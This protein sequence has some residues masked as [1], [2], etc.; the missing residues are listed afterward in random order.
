MIPPDDATGAA[1]ARAL[2]TEERRAWNAALDLWRVRMGDPALVDA[3]PDVPSFA[4]FGFPPRVHVDPDRAAQLGADD[5]LES[6]FA[7]EIGHHVLS[8][9]TRLGSLTLAAQMGRAVLAANVYGIAPDRMQR[10]AQWLSNVWSDLLINTRIVEMQR[11]RGERPTGMERLWVAVN[12]SDDPTPEW[13]VLLRATEIAWGRP[14]GTFCPIEPPIAPADEPVAG[15]DE[16]R[17]PTDLRADAELLVRTLRGFADDPVRGALRF[18][19][20]LAPYLM[21]RMRDGSGGAGGSGTG[22]VLCDGE[23]D[24][25]PATAA[26][27]ERVLADARLAE[28]PVHPA[29]EVPDAG[30]APADDADGTVSAAGGQK[31][32][33][34]ETLQLFPGAAEADA[35]SAWYQARARPHVAPLVE[36]APARLGDDIPGALALW[37]LGDDPTD[38][39]WTASLAHSI[40]V[41]PGVTTRTREWIAEEQLPDERG[42]DLDIYLDSSGSMPAPSA[43]SPAVL[44]GTILAL[45]VLRGGGRVRATSW[46]SRGQVAGSER[47]IRERREVLGML[48]TYFGG[49]T[50]FPLD[51]YQRRYEG[52]PEPGRR[53]HVVV[54]SDDGL[55]SMFGAGQDQF[56]DVAARVGRTLDTGTLVILGVPSAVDDEAAA[57]GYSVLRVASMDDAPAACARLARRIL[58]AGEPA[59]VR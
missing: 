26:E 13:W 18:G 58:E 23:P 35:V 21:E 19:M 12:A 25:A 14:A 32:D 47:F 6:V 37:E 43:G 56:A 33:V 24:A 4:W 11:R 44:A 39:D 10:K 8:P 45:S 51:L 34:A 49:G 54:L 36:R 1:P 29:T 27:L 31:Y 28:A 59:H 41:L 52:P 2:T 20:L 42:V 17:P 7:H 5:E 9:S 40:D 22:G 53:R 30:G 16:Y 38:V 57:A 15:V 46:S 50:T 55:S 48:A 3:P